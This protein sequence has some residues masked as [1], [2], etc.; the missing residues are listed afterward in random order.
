MFDQKMQFLMLSFV[1]YIRETFDSQSQAHHR[2]QIKT[3]SQIVEDS[4]A[5]NDGKFSD[6]ADVIRLI[7]VV[8]EYQHRT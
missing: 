7:L 5:M 1:V 6:Y 8:K 3:H 4:D 2:V